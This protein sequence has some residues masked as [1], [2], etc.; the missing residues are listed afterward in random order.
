MAAGGPA[1]GRASQRPHAP[2]QHRRGQCSDISRAAPVP[3]RALRSLTYR[4]GPRMVSYF[5]MYKYNKN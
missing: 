5:A 4:A 3:L 1:G 2:V